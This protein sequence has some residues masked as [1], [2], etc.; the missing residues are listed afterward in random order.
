M[1][2]AP[3]PKPSTDQTSAEPC[4]CGCCRKW[5]PKIVDLASELAQLRQREAELQVLC[6][7]EEC[8]AERAG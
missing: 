8:K 6:S 4:R 3:D 2:A 1:T 5:V 7:C